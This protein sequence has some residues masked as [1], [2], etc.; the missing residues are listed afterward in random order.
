MTLPSAGAFVSAPLNLKTN[1]NLHIPLGLS[2]PTYRVNDTVAKKLEQKMVITNLNAVE[3]ID[4]ISITDKSGKVVYMYGVQRP[5]LDSIVLPAFDFNTLI[6][7]N[8]PYTI[9]GV[10]R[11]S[12]CGV[13][14]STAI[15]MAKLNLERILADPASS[16]WIY[17]SLGWGPFQQGRAPESQFVLNFDPSLLITSRA[18]VS[19]SLELGLQPFRV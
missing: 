1:P 3:Q 18:S 13:Q 5:R 9:N 8:A 2:Y 16:N 4:S 14:R 15:L 6:A 19:D 17:S 7:E 10:V 11:T 12:T